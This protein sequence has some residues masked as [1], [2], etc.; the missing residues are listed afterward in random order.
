MSSTDSRHYR[1]EELG[2]GIHAAIARP[3]GFAICNS[4]VT[5]LGGGGVVFDSGMTP[6]SARDLHHQATRLL[7]RP[8]SVAVTSH[9]HLDHILGN[10]EFAHIPIW[11]TRRTREIL[12]ETADQ[13][14][15]EVRREQLERDIAE[16][17]G[18]R[19]EMRTDAGREDLE[20]I[21]QINRA[22]LACAGRLKVVPPDHTFE[23]RMT[24]PGARAA[25]LV[26]L[27][28]GHTE[29]DAFLFLP[30]E[31]VLFAGDL[32]VIGVQP[33]MGNGDPEHWVEELDQVVRMA[34]ERVVPGHGPVTTVDGI[35]ET[36]A[37][38]SGILEAARAPPGAPL[39]AAL[40]RWEGSLSLESNL[41]FARGWVE[42]H[43]SH[44]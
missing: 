30:R 21:L 5:D 26:S 37:Y 6:D 12:L 41:A 2:E 35:L 24:L 42:A 38:L 11:G 27:G 29:A 8:P 32:V 43:R 44:S 40:R 31:K 14:L 16:L 34:P 20:F 3:E 33:S 1:F 9:R 19:G 18:R 10:S 15:A 4:G 17:E 13:L 28:S 36:R 39:P 7:G 22:A 25:E 23:T